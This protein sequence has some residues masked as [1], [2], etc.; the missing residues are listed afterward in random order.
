MTARPHHDLVLRDPHLA[1]CKVGDVRSEHDGRELQTRTVRSRRPRAGTRRAAAH[2]AVDRVGRVRPTHPGIL[3]LESRGERQPVRRLRDR[4]SGPVG[5]RVEGRHHESGTG[6]GQ[7]IQQVTRRVTRPDQ[8]GEHPVDGPG[9]QPLLEP[10]RGGPCD[11]VSGD[12]RVLHWR[13]PPPGRKHREVQVDPAESRDIEQVRRNESAVG[14]HR[15]AVQLK[16][17][18]PVAEHAVAKRS[19]RQHLQAGVECS[20]LHRAGRDGAPT[21]ARSIGPR[22]HRDHLVLGFEQGLEHGNGHRWGT[23]KEQTHA[24]DPRRRAR[25]V[26]T[27]PDGSSA[28]TTRV[29]QRMTP[30]AARSR[31][32]PSAS[33]KGNPM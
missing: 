14:D 11:L 7:A 15:C 21:A 19:G 17:H 25:I 16:R 9:V 3:D 5:D 27:G 33:S 4:Q 31:R 20:L 8:L 22:K 26:P 12:H 13:G 23:G 32:R 10:E 29:G 1:R 6:H 18:Q 2:P 30:Q 28:V 24:V